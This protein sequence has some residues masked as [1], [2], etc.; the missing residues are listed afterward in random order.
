MNFYNIYNIIYIIMNLQKGI[1]FEIYISE[2]LQT[3]Y[4]NAEIYLWK[5]IPTFAKAKL[6]NARRDKSRYIVIY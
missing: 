2:Y 1:E 6:A 5:N 3:I 4:Q